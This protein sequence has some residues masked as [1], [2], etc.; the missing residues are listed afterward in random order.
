M[1]E[2]YARSLANTLVEEG[3]YSNHPND[4]GGPTMRGVI[5]RTYDGYRRGKGL[6]TQ[7]VRNISE[8]E[9]Q[10]IY[11]TGY[12]KRIQ[13]EKWPKGPDQIAFDIAVNSGPGR[14]WA[15]AGSVLGQPR[16]AQAV[17]L[18]SAQSADRVQLVKNLCARRAAFYQGLK[19]F[20]TFGKGWMRRN[21]RME[22]IGVKMALEGDNAAPPVIR[23]KLGEERDKAKD[24]S[25]NAGKGAAGAGGVG[26]ATGGGST[27]VPAD[28]WDW[29]AIVTVGLVVLALAGLTV[30]LI[31][32]WRRHGERAKAYAMAA[33]G[34]AEVKLVDVMHKI[35]AP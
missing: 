12:A 28:T 33:K 14:T 26:G 27:Q 23:E 20:G 24:K 19:T 10:D 15:L 35:G 1:F 29:S 22:A 7:D 4:P 18:T 25:D 30:F 8:T 6:S 31:W 9:L 21:A 3:G 32:L 2:N 11:W 5:Q 34:V 13:F 17:I 16:N